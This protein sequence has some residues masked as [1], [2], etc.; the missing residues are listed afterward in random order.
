MR[1][2][3]YRARAPI[4]NCLLIL[5]ALLAILRQ[6]TSHQRPGASFHTLNLTNWALSGHQIKQRYLIYFLAI[7]THEAP[8]ANGSALR[9]TNWRN[10][11]GCHLHATFGSARIDVEGTFICVVYRHHQSG[12]YIRT[13]IERCETNTIEEAEPVY[14]M[15][16]TEGSGTKI[17]T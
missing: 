9:T 13:L 3:R 17:A 2:S 11:L 12:T 8:N 14:V 15:S 6:A 5:L 4:V 7:F 16:E 10:F 1:T